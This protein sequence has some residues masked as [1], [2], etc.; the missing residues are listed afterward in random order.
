VSS[1][2]IVLN[3]YL[4]AFITFGISVHS[5]LAQ[6]AQ[7]STQTQTAIEAGTTQ[8]TN[9]SL[10]NTWKL[11]GE[12]WKQYTS[13]M[14]GPR[15]V[16]SPGLDP[17][18]VLGIHADS[19][20]QRRHMAELFVMREYERVEQELAFQREVSAAWERLYPGPLMVSAPTPPSVNNDD[21]LIFGDRLM[22]FVNAECTNCNNVLPIAIAKMQTSSLAMD[23][24]VVNA[25]DDI[26][27][28]KLAAA[29]H[30]PIDLVKSRRITL[31]HDA[32]YLQTLAQASPNLPAIFHKRGEIIEP[33]TQRS[34]E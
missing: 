31:N 10:A 16:W 29:N 2:T 20:E 33:L 12:E 25:P 11:T 32:G 17:L 8:N 9:Q 21:S 15:G 4:I 5:A 1:V 27:I 19:Q 13:L 34:L 30:I 14:K 6:D 7:I 23:L 22:I 26:H 24:Y 28:R 18:T 3:R